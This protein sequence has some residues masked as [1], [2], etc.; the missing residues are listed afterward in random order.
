MTRR[1]FVGR[2]A[3]AA[4]IPLLAAASNALAQEAGSKTATAPATRAIAFLKATAVAGRVRLSCFK[5]TPFFNATQ[6]EPKDSVR[7][8]IWR[9]D[10]LGFRFGHDYDEFFNGL[11]WQDAR[12][13]FEGPLSAL[14]NRKFEFTDER[15]EPGQ[16]YAYW[17]ATDRGDLPTG[18]AAVKVRDPRVWWTWEEVQRRL[19]RLAADFPG[20][21][22]LRPV[23]HTVQGR[24]LRALIAGNRERVLV[25]LGS[26]H[27]GEAGAE[28]LI[29]AFEHVVRNRR[30]LLDRV[31]LAVLPCVNADQRQRLALGYP[32]YLRT[33]ANGVDLNRNFPADWETVH[34]GYGLVT[35][36][37]E[38]MTY[39][40]ATPGSEPETQAVMR[41]LEKLKP[42]AVV[43]FHHLASITGSSFL[44]SAAAAKNEPYLARCRPLNRA[45]RAALAPPDLEKKPVAVAAGCTSGSLPTWVFQR[46]GVPAFDAEGDASLACQK[47][48]T[49]TATWED[50]EQSQASHQR[51]VAALLSALGESP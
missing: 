12:L 24:P 1:A 15:V 42:A 9:A 35:S 37:P 13:I 14:N 28:L 39:R 25:M 47:A 33:N 49:D 21:V 32:P 7:L 23:G 22:E 2:T 34:Y 31:G 41:L 3:G 29:P 19:D 48:I 10:L 8:R 17:V 16:T 50:L 11:R 40:G 45:Y 18:P 27:A 4:A 36:D 5:S 30:A 20:V 6:K 51:A 43:A 46:F 38:S 44:C 26:V